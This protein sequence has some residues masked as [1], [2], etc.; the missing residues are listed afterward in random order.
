ME[1]ELNLLYQEIAER[2]NQ[3]IPERWSDFYFYAQISKTGGGIYFY[4]KS[5]QHGDYIYN[6]DIPNLFKIDSS[7]FKKNEYELYKTSKKIQEVFKNNHQELWYS[8]TMSLE[9]TGK[10]KIHYDY[11]NWLETD[12][13]FNNQMVIWKYKYLN[14]KPQNEELQKVINKYLVEYPNNPI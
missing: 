1:K 8:F 4:Y 9:S 5:E 3:M 12:Y 11:T 14:E 10:F 6:L 13:S 7:N 2:I